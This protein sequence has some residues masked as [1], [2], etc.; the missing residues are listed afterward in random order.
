MLITHFRARVELF[1]FFVLHPSRSFTA[2]IKA[3]SKGA[4]W[5]IY[6]FVKCKVATIPAPLNI[7]VIVP[8]PAA[9]YQ[10]NVLYAQE[11]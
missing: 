11:R 2:H 5:I 4:S 10:W 9:N 6:G 3:Q 7:L 8:F 1:M